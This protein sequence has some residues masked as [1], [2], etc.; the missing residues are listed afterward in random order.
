MD[1]SSK[2]SI[3]A[4]KVAGKKN[5]VTAAIV[6]ITALS[7][8]VAIATFCEVSAS[9]VLVEARRRLFVESRCAISL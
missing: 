2:G 6:R 1:T 4:V 5:I 9:S 3:T 8:E 7:R